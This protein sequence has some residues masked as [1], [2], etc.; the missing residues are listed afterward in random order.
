MF[1]SRPDKVDEFSR[2]IINLDGTRLRTLGHYCSARLN[3]G[4]GRGAV[5][6]PLADLL[7][8]S[9]LDGPPCLGPI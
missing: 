2:Q 1:K 8:D 6:V 3:E 4:F 7:H 9:A 5:Y